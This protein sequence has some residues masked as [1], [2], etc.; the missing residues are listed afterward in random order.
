MIV[1]SPLESGDYQNYR[2]YHRVTDS[3]KQTERAIT[4]NLSLS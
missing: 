3:Y 1:K 4:H 2:N